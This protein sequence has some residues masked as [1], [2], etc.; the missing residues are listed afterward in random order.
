MAYEKDRIRLKCAYCGKEFMVADSVGKRKKF[1]SKWCKDDSERD[2]VTRT[3]KNCKR[4]FLLPRWEVNKGRGNFCGRRCY[5]HFNGESSIEALMRRA[6]EKAKINFKQE[7]QFGKFY[8]DFL[9]PERKVVI[10]CDGDYWHGS[11]KIKAR[12]ERKD[13]FLKARGYR[14]YRFSEEKIK[15]SADGCVNQTLR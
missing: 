2:Y 12:D 15:L 1:C 9:L 3:C 7:V 14:I 4:D 11:Q 8:V 10:E 6:L 5:V 13:E